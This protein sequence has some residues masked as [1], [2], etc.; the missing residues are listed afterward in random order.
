MGPS[1]KTDLTPEKNADTQSG[2][3]RMAMGIAHVW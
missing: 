3:Q 2:K 1:E